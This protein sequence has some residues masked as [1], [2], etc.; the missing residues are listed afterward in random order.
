MLLLQSVGGEN[1][2]APASLAAPQVDPQLCF[3]SHVLLDGCEEKG[4]R[5]PARVCASNQDFRL[6]IQWMEKCGAEGGRRRR[7]ERLRGRGEDNGQEDAAITR[8]RTVWQ[9]Q[10]NQTQHRAADRAVA[11]AAVGR[12]F[13]CEPCVDVLCTVHSILCSMGVFCTDR[14]RCALRFTPAS[15]QSTRDPAGCGTV[16][17]NYRTGQVERRARRQREASQL[18]RW[19]WA[20]PS[21]VV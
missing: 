11:A 5:Q 9:K 6:F 18:A 16:L 4:P 7:S 14:S 17:C 13:R 3:S 21:A 10:K 20:V 15:R 8:D 1:I 2:G 19:L 12:V